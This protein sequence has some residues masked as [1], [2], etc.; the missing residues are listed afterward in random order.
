[1]VSGGT[2]VN[3]FA[4]IP[5]TVEVKFGN[6]PLQVNKISFNQRNI[7]LQITT[8]IITQILF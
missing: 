1:M 3:Y 8:T 7:P 2:E 4:K 6:N 5:L